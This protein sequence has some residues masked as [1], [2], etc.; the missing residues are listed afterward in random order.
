M[1]NA[2]LEDAIAIGPH[3]VNVRQAGGDK[4]SSGK[5][6]QGD[7]ANRPSLRF[8]SFEFP[9]VECHGSLLFIAAKYSI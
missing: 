5:G 4:R 3:L 6:N 7:G 9:A 8:P 2:K 1:I